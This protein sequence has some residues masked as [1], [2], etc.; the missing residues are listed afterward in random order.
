MYIVCAATS[1]KQ[2]FIAQFQGQPIA[3]QTDEEAWNFIQEIMKKEDRPTVAWL[4][5]VPDDNS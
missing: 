3:F 1:D 5:E 2:K 4:R